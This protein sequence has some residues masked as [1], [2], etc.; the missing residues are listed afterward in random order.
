M[1]HV[2]AVIEHFN[3]LEQSGTQNSNCS[4]T[5]LLTTHIGT[6]KMSFHPHSDRLVD[7][8]PANSPDHHFQLHQEST[9]GQKKSPAE[10]TKHSLQDEQGPVPHNFCNMEPMSV[11]NIVLSAESPAQQRQQHHMNW[12]QELR[13]IRGLLRLHDTEGEGSFGEADLV[14]PFGTQ[15]A[16]MLS[17]ALQTAEN[18]ALRVE[19][20]VK[21]GKIGTSVIEPPRFQN[22][23]K[24]TKMLLEESRLTNALGTPLRTKLNP[25]AALVAEQTLSSPSSPHYLHQHLPTLSSTSKRT[26]KYINTKTRPSIFMS[27]DTA[28]S[29][30]K[31]G[32]TN[33]SPAAVIRPPD[34]RSKLSSKPSPTQTQQ[35]LAPESSPAQRSL[36][37]LLAQ[38]PKRKPP[39]VP[40]NKLTQQSTSTRSE[41]AF[42]S[43]KTQTAL[44][45]RTRPGPSHFSKPKPKPACV[46]KG[47]QGRTEHVGKNPSVSAKN[48][49]N[50]VPIAT[51]THHAPPKPQPLCELGLP[52]M[53]VQMAPIA[54]PASSIVKS[55]RIPRPAWPVPQQRN[56][57]TLHNSGLDEKGIVSSSS[58]RAKSQIVELRECQERPNKLRSPYTTKKIGTKTKSGPK[59]N[60]TA[61]K[62]SGSSVKQYVSGEARASESGT[63]QRKLTRQA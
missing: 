61:P 48:A 5:S 47:R 11:G 6:P 36:F 19:L 43:D 21:G 62:Q 10:A 17:K 50:P 40:A 30:T 1:S 63:R 49:S 54:A 24:A 37:R 13:L 9:P 20:G 31:T 53:N 42:S 25:H 15:D 51:A 26:T 34:A 58:L 35:V 38:P 39:T 28:E 41:M 16:R 29:S 27:A 22:K 8:T 44:E 12:K 18:L 2:K 3:S 55:S 45:I 52:R 60:N 56:R 32:Y 4:K 14:D 23:S 57:A 46:I 7:E 59:G 33:C